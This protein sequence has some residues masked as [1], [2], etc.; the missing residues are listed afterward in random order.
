MFDVFQ[1]TAQD[2][3]VVLTDESGK[4]EWTGFVTPNLYD[5]GFETDKEELEIIYKFLQGLINYLLI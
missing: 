3:S 4:V 5:M 1:S 2:V